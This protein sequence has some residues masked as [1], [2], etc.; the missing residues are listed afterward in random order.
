MKMAVA[1]SYNIFWLN[2]WTHIK[3][4]Q[5]HFLAE[6]YIA[7]RKTARSRWFHCVDLQS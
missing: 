1:W 3:V 5:Q 7:I 2:G 6:I 4:K